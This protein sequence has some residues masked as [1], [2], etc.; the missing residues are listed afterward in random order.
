[1]ELA[2]WGCFT[3][4]QLRSDPLTAEGTVSQLSAPESTENRCK[5]E[6]G[7]WTGEHFVLA[8]TALGPDALR[9]SQTLQGLWQVP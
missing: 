2:R 8:D 9:C 7:K 3:S 5:H 6:P 1:M 4:C